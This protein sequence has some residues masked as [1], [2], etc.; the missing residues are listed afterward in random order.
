[1]R[2][3]RAQKVEGGETI[4]IIT[5]CARC[6]D[7]T[8]K[9]SEERGIHGLEALDHG[10]LASTACRMETPELKFG[11]LL[12]LCSHDVLAVT[13]LHYGSR[14]QSV[15]LLSVHVVTCRPTPGVMAK[16]DD[17]CLGDIHVVCIFLDPVQS[18]ALVLETESV[19]GRLGSIVR[20]P[21]EHQ[22]AEQGKPILHRDYG[23]I[24]NAC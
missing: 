22:E 6:T 5:R 13:R 12:K 23:E 24:L 10:R 19:K 1:M 4:P 9:A 2:P 3:S 16:D 7:V 8:P 21:L 20:H 15:T 11:P 18:E 17:I 14:L